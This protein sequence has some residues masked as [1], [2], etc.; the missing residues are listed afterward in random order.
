MNTLKSMIKIFRP[1]RVFRKKTLKKLQ[2]IENGKYFEDSYKDTFYE[3]IEVCEQAVSSTRFLIFWFIVFIASAGTTIGSVFYLVA[4]DNLV[5]SLVGLL[6]SIVILVTS[7]LQDVKFKAEVKS[8][9][10][11]LSNNEIAEAMKIKNSGR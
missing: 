11:I 3:Y 9:F 7:V 1:N 5:Y 8:S 6:W 4:G 2:E 10:A